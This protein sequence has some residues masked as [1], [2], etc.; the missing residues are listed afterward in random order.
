VLPD[1]A[2]LLELRAGRQRLA[3]DDD[4]SDHEDEARIAQVDPGLLEFGRAGVAAFDV[5]AGSESDLADLPDT[6]EQA[7]L[8]WLARGGVLLI[9]AP[10]EAAARVLPEDAAPTA[11]GWRRVGRGSVHATD[12]A[13][14]DG[15]FPDVL[16]PTESGGSVEDGHLAF[17]MGNFGMQEFAMPIEMTLAQGAGFRLPEARDLLILLLVYAVLVGPVSSL[18]LRKLGK[19]TLAWATVPALAA[20]FTGAVY[21]QGEELRRSTG[22]SYSTVLE[23]TPYGTTATVHVL[24][25]SKSGGESVLSAPPNWS[26]STLANPFEFG[27]GPAFGPGF[28]A[29]SAREEVAQLAD[30]TEIGVDLSPGEFRGLRLVGEL[31]GQPAVTAVATTNENGHADVVVT[32]NLTVEL[33]DVVVFVEDEYEEIGSIAGGASVDVALDGLD[34]QSSA[35]RADTRAWDALERGNPFFD[36]FGMQ[37]EIDDPL[38]EPVEPGLWADT[39]QRRGQNLRIPGEVAVVGWTTELPSPVTQRGTDL[40]E[41]HT[42][43]IARAAI[44]AGGEDLADTAVTRTLVRANGDVRWAE[45]GGFENFGGGSAS[46]VYRFLVPDTVGDRAVDLDRL[47]LLLPE[48]TKRAEWYTRDGWLN[49]YPGLGEDRVVA[50]PPEALLSGSLYVRFDPISDLRAGRDDPQVFELPPGSDLEVTTPEELASLH[51]FFEDERRAERA[52]SS[53]PDADDEGRDL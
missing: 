4:R 5:L 21:V 18:V 11:I 45:W 25:G 28:D 15:G 34:G 53:S 47:V 51:Q 52:S 3:F 14:A 48:R 46:G 50:I 1:L 39:L 20:V 9:D 35:N 29:E 2:S 32:N 27:F 38:A 8:H 7:L 49:L 37:R 31:P 43:I 12:G 13:I 24:V 40:L 26:T 42:M 36:D 33:H 23:V 22:T 16:M 6:H 41:G 19:R 30:R 10:A 17:G 44:E